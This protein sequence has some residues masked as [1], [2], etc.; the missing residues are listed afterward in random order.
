[1]TA[2]KTAIQDADVATDADASA[3]D[4]DASAA[5]ADA[6]A[7]DANIATDA[8]AGA[9][10]SREGLVPRRRL[11][12]VILDWAGTTQDFGS[13]APVGAF[14]EAFA[15]FGVAI[16]VA[17]ARGPMGI[18][19]LDHIRAIAAYPEVAAMWLSVHGSA[20]GEDD[21]QA[22]YRE[23][24]PIQEAVLPQFCAL[25]PGT[26]EAVAEVR[27]RG[28]RVGSTTGY[29]RSVGEIAARHAFEQGYE[30]EVMV[31]ADEVPAGRPEPW[32]LLRAMEQ[33]RVFPPYAVVKVG[34]TAADIEEG[35]N[36]G[37][38]TVGITR[39][40]NYVGLDR[41]QLASLPAERKAEMILA[42]AD[43]LRDSGAHYLIGSIAD[44][45]PVLDE[46][47]VRLALGHRP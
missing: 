16:T 39:T 13:L 23:L 25:I 28:Y 5:D 37:T 45:P 32:M 17:Q 21:V 7:A 14:V 33:L 31:C 9:T 36:A 19:K 42:A 34:D 4:A 22:M 1:M 46:I 41:E 44:L 11:R 3:A 20:C 40:G 10:S 43:K 8:K 12:A 30:P 6:S 38:W 24:V 2:T 27:A 15:R 18:Y 29:P 26:L 47:E 35:L